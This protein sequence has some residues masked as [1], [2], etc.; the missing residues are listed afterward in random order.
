MMRVRSA[1]DFGAI[2]RQRRRDEKLSQAELAHRA[3]VT[4][5]WLVG[6]EKGNP[7]VSVAKVFAIFR[8]LD[9]IIRI[10]PADGRSEPRAYEIPVTVKPRLAVER[11]AETLQIV[12]A[13]ADRRTDSTEP[14]RSRDDG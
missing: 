2:A 7:E 1:S 12:A 4:R 3:G 8:E 5:Q 11:I 14:A 10:D 6:F 13:A 9:A